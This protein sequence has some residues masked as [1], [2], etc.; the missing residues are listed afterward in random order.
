KRDEL[1]NLLHDD[2]DM[3]DL[4]LSKKLANL[5]S[6]ATSFGAPN[7]LLSSPNPDSKIHRSSK[8]STTTLVQVEKD[9]EE[10]EMLLQVT[11]TSIKC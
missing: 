2:D 7:W 3:D 5:S 4:Y 6:L 1:E 11:R 10:L 8:A 9:V